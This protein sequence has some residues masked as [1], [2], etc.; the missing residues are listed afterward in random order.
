M[1][2][3]SWRTANMFLEP[4]C[5]PAHLFLGTHDDNNADKLRKGRRSYRRGHEVGTSRLTAEQ[6]IAIRAAVAG[7]ESNSSVGRRFGVSHQSVRRAVL[8]ESWKHL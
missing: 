3:G 5:N 7:G 4:C 8:R 6:V 1:S 2:R